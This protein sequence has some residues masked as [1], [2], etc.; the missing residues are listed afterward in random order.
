ML[1]AIPH[2]WLLSSVV[3][4]RAQCWVQCSFLSILN[5]SLNWSITFLSTTIFSQMIPNCI[6][7]FQSRVIRPL[8]LLKTCNSVALQLNTGWIAIN[9]NLMIQKLKHCSVGRHSGESPA[10]LDHCW[11]V[12]PLLSFL[13]VSNLLE[14]SLTVIYLLKSRFLL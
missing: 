4:H 1:T 3:S 9:L 11:W 13:P 14:F 8:R 12:T 2:Q 5:N 6:P 10:L 7:E